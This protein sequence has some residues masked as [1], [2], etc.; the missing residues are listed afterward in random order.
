MLVL[1]ACLLHYFPFGYTRSGVRET[2]HKLHVDQSSEIKVLL[3]QLYYIQSNLDLHQTLL[4]YVSAGVEYCMGCSL[5][6]LW[7]CV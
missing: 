5:L 6:M 4:L 2:T 3:E 1:C 7:K